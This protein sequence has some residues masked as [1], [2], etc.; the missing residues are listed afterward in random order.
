MYGMYGICAFPYVTFMPLCLSNCV[1]RC[2][3]M[4]TSL[5]V[6]INGFCLK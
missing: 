4:L 3:Y 6:G 1:K 5:Q 2:P